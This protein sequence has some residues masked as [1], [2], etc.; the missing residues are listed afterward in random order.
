MSNVISKRAFSILIWI[1][2]SANAA[3]AL[4]AWASARAKAAAALVAELCVCLD[5][6]DACDLVRNDL[7]P[8]DLLSDIL[9]NIL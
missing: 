1:S 9:E 2:F 4:A 8:V 7:D 6:H 3:S 5:E